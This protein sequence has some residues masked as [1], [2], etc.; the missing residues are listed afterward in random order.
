[1]V[2]LPV[3]ILVHIVVHVEGMCVTL[4]ACCNVQQAV[5]C[6][7]SVGKHSVV[8]KVVCCRVLRSSDIV[9]SGNEIQRCH[10]QFCGRGGWMK[11]VFMH[12]ALTRMCEWV[13]GVCGSV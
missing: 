2:C 10:E 12:C 7:W 11:W 6:L 9:I 3:H 1:M 8:N 4:H 5:L 13:E